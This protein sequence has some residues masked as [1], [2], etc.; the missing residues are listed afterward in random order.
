MDKLYIEENISSNDIIK[1]IAYDNN[2]SNYEVLKTKNGKPYFRVGNKDDEI[3]F[4]ISNK[5]NITVAVA[6]SNPVGID[7]ER[8]TFK[9]SVVKHFFSKNEQ[10]I[11]RESFDKEK[12]FTNIWIK[13]E[14][15]I[16]Y[17]GL[18][19]TSIRKID[20]TKLTGFVIKRYKDYLIGIFKE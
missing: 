5:N 20:T 11:I 2:L 8:L 10:E 13:K 16:K 1:K 19:L 12:D 14:A 4:N 18:D 17:L 9:S 15:Y 6:S 7:I 3:H